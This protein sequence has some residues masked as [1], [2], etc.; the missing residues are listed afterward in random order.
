MCLTVVSLHLYSSH[1]MA[2]VQYKFQILH[3]SRSPETRPAGA[4]IKFCVRIKR[5]ITTANATIKAT[6]FAVPVFTSKGQ[7]GPF[8]YTSV[9]LVVGKPLFPLLHILAA[10][11]IFN[12]TSYFVFLHIPHHTAFDVMY[13]SE[14]FQIRSSLLP[15]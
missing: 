6:F 7:F 13:I 14:Y 15:Y 2:F 11:F 4:R 12:G 10:I 5:I 8:P 1:S 3:L 9:I